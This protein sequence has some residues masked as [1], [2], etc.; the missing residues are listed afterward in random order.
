MM[1][2]NSGDGDENEYGDDYGDHDG[3][4]DDPDICCDDDF[5]SHCQ[6]TAITTMTLV[7]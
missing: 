6:K 7:M 1:L 4:D 3:D 5:D 2:S